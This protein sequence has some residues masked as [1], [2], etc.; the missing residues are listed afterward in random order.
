[1]IT[2]N[3]G[4]PGGGVSI[5][6]RGTSSITGGAEPLF[7]VA[8]VIIDNNA[9]QQINVGYRSNPINRLAE[10]DPSDIERIEILKGAAA[11]ALFG[12]R[13]N[14]GV[15]QIFTRRGRA[16]ATRFTAS[17][18]ATRSDLPR[19]IPFAL[20]PRNPDGTPAVRYDHQD[21]LFRNSMGQDHHV[22]ASGGAENTRYYLSANYTDRDGIMIG[23]A[24]NKLNARLNLDQDFGRGFSLSAGAN[25]VRS[26][27]DLVVSGEQAEGGLLTAIVFTPTT[28]NLA[29]RNPET[30]ALVYD[31]GAF[32][33]PLG[34]VEGWDLFQVVDR[35]VGSMQARANPLA[36]LTLEY[37]LGYD[38]YQMETGSS[39][40]ATR[41]T[42]PTR[43]RSPR[44][45]TTG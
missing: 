1:V 34:V 4:T 30:G 29:E 23:S 14:N 5:R 31:G 19:R 3:T 43:G 16:G 28:V 40:R 11:A 37:R 9:D 22:S 33:N 21:L 13:A 32:P 24:H 44:T 41:R 8:G 45:G 36:D 6:L 35:F 38:T 10:L 7:I 39:S 42:P 18:R 2:S 25:Y 26:H 27:T 15:V 20:T 17:T 12:S